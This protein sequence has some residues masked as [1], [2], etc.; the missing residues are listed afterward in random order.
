MPPSRFTAPPG[1]DTAARQRNAPPALL[2]QSSKARLQHTMHLLCQAFMNSWTRNKFSDTIYRCSSGYTKC[3]RWRVGCEVQR[4]SA[5]RY[6]M[7]VTDRRLVRAFAV[8]RLACCFAWNQRLSQHIASLHLVEANSTIQASQINGHLGLG[9]YPRPNFQ[10]SEKMD[11]SLHSAQATICMPLV[12]TAAL[13]VVGLAH[14]VQRS[15]EAKAHVQKRQ[16]KEG[17]TGN[18]GPWNQSG[19][20]LYVLSDFH[21][22]P[23]AEKAT[24]I[25]D[26]HASISL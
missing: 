16:K 7:P 5:L 23:A 11:R 22:M 8:Q 3:S 25:T 20:C 17:C 6:K 26:N 15:Q 1:L 19:G 10:L 14:I 21:Q 12:E 18:T 9:S 24:T 4:S 2:G 13:C